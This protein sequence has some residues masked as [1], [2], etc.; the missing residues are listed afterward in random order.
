MSFRTHG[1]LLS[2]ALALGAISCGGSSKPSNNT[3]PN[4]TPESLA[5]SSA[6]SDAP[7]ASNEVATNGPAASPSSMSTTPTGGEPS[8]GSGTAADT[9]R[10]GQ[11]ELA[12]TGA[13]S[14]ANADARGTDVMASSPNAAALDD[15]QIAKITDAVNSAEIEQAKLAQQKSKNE[16]VRQ[17]AAMMIQHH[18]QAK[19]DQAALKL[20]PADSPM[21]QQL[22]AEAETTLASLKAKTGAD[23]DRAY[24]E[25]QVEAHQKV[26]QALQR[27]LEPSA[28]S[29]ALQS[30]LK[31]LATRRRAPLAGAIGPAIIAE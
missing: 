4:S 19:K 26:L 16:K 14:A 5:A 8:T 21:A 6:T 17:F 12:A 13:S 10:T 11:G 24:L 20:T 27:D 25:A 23:F 22:T 15:P 28:Q 2:S 18:G 3:P 31:K 29:P 9:A 30:Y 1:L 7:S